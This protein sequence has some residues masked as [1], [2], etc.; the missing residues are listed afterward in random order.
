MTMTTIPPCCTDSK[1]ACWA[2]CDFFWW[3]LVLEGNGACNQLVACILGSK[4]ADDSDELNENF[5][6]RKYQLL[7]TSEI[8]D[9]KRT[10]CKRT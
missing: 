7:G 9:H 5:D 1:V 6:D 8:I 4:T 3:A 10:F 2:S